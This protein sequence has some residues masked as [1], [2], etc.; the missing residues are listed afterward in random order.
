[1]KGATICT[2]ILLLPAGAAATPRAY[3]VSDG[4]RI[5]QDGQDLGAAMATG[6]AR[7]L[8]APIRIAALRD[9]VV[10][11]QIVVQADAASLE[12]VRVDV[13]PPVPVTKA[14]APGIAIERFVEH[15]VAVTAR[16]R[17]ERRPREAL[18]WMPDARPPDEAMLG[19]VPDALVPVEI[20]PSWRP[21]P[22]VIAPRQTGA[23]WVDMTVPRTAMPGSYTGAVVV[24]VEGRGEIARAP[25]VLDVAS[26]TLPYRATSFLSA[27]APSNL[28]RRLGTLAPAEMQLFQLLHQHHVDALGSIRTASDVERL[29]PALDGSLFTAAHGYTGPGEGV[30]PSAVALGAYGALGD[31]EPAK[32]AALEALLPSIPAAIE[33]VFLYAAD[34]DCKSPRARGWQRF[35]AGSSQR[36]RVRIA[37]SCDADPRK[38][39][40]DL[41]L[42]PSQRFD[43]DKAATARLLGRDVWVYNGM[44]PRSGPLLLDAP[45]TSLRADAWIAATHPVGRWFLWETTFWND[46]NQGGRGPVDPFTVAENFHNGRDDCAL[47]DGLL[48]YPGLQGGPFAGRSLGFPGVLP[49]IRLKNLRRG[50]QDAGYLALARLAHPAEADAIATRLIPAALD[51]TEDGDRTP[52]PASAAAFDAA[53]EALR[54]L[55]PA[56]AALDSRRAAA[57]LELGR[58]RRMLVRRGK[59]HPWTNRHLVFGG[60]AGFAATILGTACVMRARRRRGRDRA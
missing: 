38:Q 48:V 41:V 4:A 46:D 2:A 14:E 36:A 26:A 12:G 56:G 25:L 22:L 23:V 29:R 42:L 21:Y 45:V 57:S 37:H 49:S 7:P 15:Y 19:S 9:E 5:R 6:A 34:E 44:L 8:G 24:R 50:I 18:G 58:T 47:G 13:E 39:D 17:N 43:A 60:F 10:A 54:P 27:Y 40:V 32:V 30:A 51:E 35:F 3:V 31:P 55:V 20:A 11:F 1:L 52:F 33:D 59:L 53:R 16:S 28:E